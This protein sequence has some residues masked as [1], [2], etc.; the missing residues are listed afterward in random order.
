[1]TTTAEAPATTISPTNL[2]VANKIGITHSAVSRIRSGNR[3]VSV[4][5]MA[6]VA[7]VYNWSVEDQVNSRVAGVYAEA[8]ERVITAHTGE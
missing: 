6:R 3:N 4:E 8:F 1:M 7:A 5:V 2:E